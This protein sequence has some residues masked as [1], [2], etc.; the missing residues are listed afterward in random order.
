MRFSILFYFLLISIFSFS[1]QK[2][3][4]N[5][6]EQ[7]SIQKSQMKENIQNSPFGGEAKTPQ[8]SSNRKPMVSKNSPSKKAKKGGKHISIKSNKSDKDYKIYEGEKIVL[9]TKDG[10]R[11]KGRL[12]KI[13]APKFMVGDSLIELNEVELIKRG[14]V[15]VLKKKSSGLGLVVG[16]IVI[17][18]A[19]TFIGYASTLV[20]EEGG[21]FI[22]VTAVGITTAIGINI[23]GISV[24]I[25]GAK[26][27]SERVKWPIGKKWK[28]SLN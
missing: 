15:P 22:I 17:T 23:V 21:P 1:Q 12:N 5:L 6:R 25:E 18:A 27:A 13:Q 10:E 26:L 9:K 20:F 3:V 4:K 7:Q 11:F 19:G 8:K 24:I 2:P 28:A 14:F 16:G